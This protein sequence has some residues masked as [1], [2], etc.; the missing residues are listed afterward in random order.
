MIHA[1]DNA[2]NIGHQI[3]FLSLFI[4]RPYQIF[5]LYQDTIAIISYFEKLNLFMTFIYNPKQ[6]EITRKL[7]LYQI[8]ANRFNLTA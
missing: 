2:N 1:K 5:Q 3:V 8:T 6:S 4:G 7:L